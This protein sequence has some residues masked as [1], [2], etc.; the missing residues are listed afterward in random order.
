MATVTWCVGRRN[1]LA[2]AAVRGSCEARF[3]KYWKFTRSTLEKSKTPGR[4]CSVARTWIMEPYAAKGNVNGV[5]IGWWVAA[6]I[7]HLPLRP[8]QQL[9]RICTLQLIR[10]SGERRHLYASPRGIQLIWINSANC[11]GSV[12]VRPISDCP[13]IC[14]RPQVLYSVVISP[15]TLPNPAWRGVHRG[16]A[17]CNSRN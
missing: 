2:L 5:I 1:G 4:S 8:V 10:R 11:T 15:I 3:L 17:K 14:N 12:G 9:R 16:P 7:A 13:A 6:L